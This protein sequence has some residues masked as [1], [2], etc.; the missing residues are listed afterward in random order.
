MRESNPGSAVDSG[1]AT[2]VADMSHG[3]YAPRMT[4][5]VQCGAEFDPAKNGPEAC[6]YH[7]GPLM[8]YDRIGKLGGFPG[9]FWDCCGKQ[10]GIGGDER[11]CKKGPHVAETR[12]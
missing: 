1:T 2:L 9:D 10:W 12:P 8:D 7:P 6:E 3:C 4:R 11:G 5:C